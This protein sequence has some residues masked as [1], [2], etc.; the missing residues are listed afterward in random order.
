MECGNGFVHVDFIISP[1]Y[2]LLGMLTIST[3]EEPV[4]ARLAPYQMLGMSKYRMTCVMMS[5]VFMA[6]CGLHMDSATPSHLSI[7]QSQEKLF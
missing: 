6:S 1:L 7:L 4:L 3:R 2:C 5:L